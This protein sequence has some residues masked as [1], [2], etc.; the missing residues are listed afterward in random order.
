M[1]PPGRTA[2]CFRRPT[3]QALSCR[4]R[5]A[6]RDVNVLVS[7][8]YRTWKPTTVWP[9]SCSAR[10]DG[11][12]GQVRVSSRSLRATCHDTTPCPERTRIQR[13]TCR[14]NPCCTV[15]R[16][17]ALPP[18]PSP[19]PAFRSH[20]RNPRWRL[21]APRTTESSPAGEQPRSRGA[22]WLF[23]LHACLAAQRIGVQPRAVTCLEVP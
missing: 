9:G 15:V 4:R 6:T 18:R 22:R 21:V 1:S 7:A 12:Y 13:D 20:S 23:E 2:S 14:L 8:R 19:S 3:D 17:R 10:P 16:D 11:D 5:A